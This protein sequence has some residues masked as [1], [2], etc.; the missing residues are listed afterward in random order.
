MSK[1]NVINDNSSRV[2]VSYSH[3][4]LDLIYPLVTLMRVNLTRV[5]LDKDGIKPGKKWRDKVD[6]AI[7][8]SSLLI[9]FWCVHSRQ[10]EEVRREY[11]LAIKE[12]KD[13]VPVLLD[14]TPVVEELR[15][16][17]WID[18]QDIANHETLLKN[19]EEHTPTIA[20]QPPRP[21]G[22]VYTEEQRRIDKEKEAKS[23]IIRK[24]LHAQF[25]EIV[26]RC[27]NFLDNKLSATDR[28]DDLGNEYP[29]STFLL[30]IHRYIDLY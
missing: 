10:S 12:R 30:P 19:V 26:R 15:D 2:F 8:S 24:Q 29:N 25:T 18:L 20:C 13:V 22:W 6:D 1:A 17:Q 11:L 14:D 21:P 27:S 7:R 16:Y 23:E 5:Y 28:E 9:V 4:D 3:T